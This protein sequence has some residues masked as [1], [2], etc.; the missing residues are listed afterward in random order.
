MLQSVSEPQVTY[1]SGSEGVGGEFARPVPV[2]EAV[3]WCGTAEN[4]PRP[5]DA[6]TFTIIDPSGFFVDYRPACSNPEAFGHS[7]I[8]SLTQAEAA[9]PE[10]LVRE[11]VD[12]LQPADE[13][14][15]AGYPDNRQVPRVRVVRDGSVVAFFITNEGL[16]FIDAGWI[17]PSSG[18]SYPTQSG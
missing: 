16:K 15:L 10:D 4:V 3:V 9:S 8:P 17:C 12:G 11:V 7:P 14:D 6:A 5:A 2:G 13:V 1:A 18:L